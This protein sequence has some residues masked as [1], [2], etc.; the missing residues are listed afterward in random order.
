MCSWS[1]SKSVLQRTSACYMFSFGARRYCVTCIILT[2]PLFITSINFLLYF[3]LYNYFS[4]FHCSVFFLI[5]YFDILHF[6]LQQYFVMFISDLFS[7]IYTF[8]KMNSFSSFHSSFFRY[9]IFCP[10]II[11]L[12]NFICKVF[13]F[14]Y[15]FI[16]AC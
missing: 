3:C 9:S 11:N 12:K 10:I 2:L 14:T 8:S 13:C 1:E 16:P 6:F 4:L 15:L 7:V 5:L